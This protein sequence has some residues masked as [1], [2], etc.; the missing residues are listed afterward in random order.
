MGDPDKGTEYEFTLSDG[1]KR[2][3]IVMDRKDVFDFKKLHK[4]VSAQPVKN[5]AS[6]R[7]SS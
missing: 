4:A 1:S 6:S 7:S 2:Y 3:E 5:N